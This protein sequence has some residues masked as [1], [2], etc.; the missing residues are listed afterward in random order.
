MRFICILVVF[1]A[2]LKAGPP[3]SADS[4]DEAGKIVNKPAAHVAKVSGGARQTITAV[5]PGPSP[6]QTEKSEAWWMTFLGLALL[7]TSAGAFF[8]PKVFMYGRRSGFWREL[9]GEQSTA[10]MVRVISF[11]IGVA[12][13]LIMLWGIFTIL[14]G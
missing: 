3:A 14:E 2:A 7:L 1:L 11:T 12:G 10:T 5:H 4:S 13:T 6:K 9:I 8:S